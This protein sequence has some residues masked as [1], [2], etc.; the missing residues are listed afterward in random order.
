MFSACF[1]QIFVK[2]KLPAIYVAARV[3]FAQMI[4]AGVLAIPEVTSASGF[5]LSSVTLVIVWS[6]C[7]ATGLLVAECSGDGRESIQKMAEASIGPSAGNAM[8]A[9]FLVSNY[10][11]MVAYIC[12]GTTLLA[13]VPD[14]AGD[15]CGSV[16]KHC[17]TDLH[18]GPIVFTAVVG[19]STLWGPKHLVGQ[20]N[21]FLVGLIATAFV[22]LV[23]T[24]VCHIDISSLYSTLDTSSL[25][26]MLPVALCALGF[27]NIVPAVSKNL[28]GDSKKI[29]ASLVIGSGIPLLICECLDLYGVVQNEK[30]LMHEVYGSLDDLFIQV[31]YFLF[32]CSRWEK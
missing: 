22:G 3:S 30:H 18:L 19:C 8:C 27:Q 11:L 17:L 12:Q 5:I 14:M 25:P 7:L 31:V 1:W 21:T 6:Y 28:A 26:G 2:H 16:L 4:G 10:L 13:R 9:T 24:G 29:R 23:W 20:A 32:T 15:V